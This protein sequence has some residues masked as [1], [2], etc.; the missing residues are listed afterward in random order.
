LQYLHTI[1]ALGADIGWLLGP[2]RAGSMAATSS[3][4]QHTL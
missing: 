4:L 3:Q 2:D 1:Q